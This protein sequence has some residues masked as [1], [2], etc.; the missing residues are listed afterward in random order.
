MYRAKV[1]AVDA[2]GAYI[3]TAEYGV[4]GPCQVVGATPDVDDMVLAVNVGTAS[5]PDLIVVGT[6][7]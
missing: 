6:I 4:L 3:Q 1:T 2:S 5:A 7:T